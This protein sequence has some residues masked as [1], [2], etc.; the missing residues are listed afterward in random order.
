M[1]ANHV[2]NYSYNNCSFC[3]N[4]FETSST[5]IDTPKHK[6]SHPCVGVYGW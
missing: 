4:Y 5:G 6:I 2:T 1:A 3:I